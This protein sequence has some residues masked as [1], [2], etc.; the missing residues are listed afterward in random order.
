MQ[1]TWLPQPAKH[2]YAAAINYL[3]LLMKPAT[4]TRVVD[5]LATV[6]DT[7]FHAKDI[8]RA[9]RLPLLG[10]DDASVARELGKVSAGTAISPILLVRGSLEHGMALQIADGY[11]RTC[12]A[13]HLG[14]DQLIPVRIVDA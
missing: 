13:Y 8:L 11:H 1:V 10:D 14:E 5:K 9:A 2:D 7:P 6:D 4:A 3:T 12:A